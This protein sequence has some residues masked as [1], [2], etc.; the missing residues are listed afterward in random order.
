M[1]TGSRDGRT[2]EIS[3]S[4]VGGGGG[5]LVGVAMAGEVRDGRCYR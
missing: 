5:E 1:I 4:I 3:D 2:A